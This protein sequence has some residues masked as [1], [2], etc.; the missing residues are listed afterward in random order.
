[1]VELIEDYY[2]LAAESS[3]EPMKTEKKGSSSF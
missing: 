1:M 3:Y 2:F